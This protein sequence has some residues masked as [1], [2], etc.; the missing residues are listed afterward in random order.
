MVLKDISIVN[1]K[2]I[3]DAT[4]K[5]S[6]NINCFIGHNGEGKTNMLDAIYYMS[7]CRSAFTHTDSLTINHD[8]DFFVIQGNYENENGDCEE[9][10]CGMKRGSKKHIRRNK[11]EYRRFSEHIGLIPIIFISPSDT[12]L[13]DGGSEDRRHLLDIV[14]AQYDINYITALS[15]YNKALQQRNALL[16]A[17][18]EPDATLMELLEMQMAE[19]GET[20]YRKRDAF[21]EKLK[22]I[23]QDFYSRISQD[24][25]RVTLNYVSHCQ[26]GALLDVISRDRMKDRAV[27]YSLH[28]IHRDD[29]EMMIGDYQMKREASQGQRKTFVLALKLAQF[30]FLRQT[31]SNTTPLL[32]L[33]DIFDKLDASRVEQIVQL[34]SGDR[35]GQIFITDT[36]RE[37]LDSI[38][39]ASQDDYK[40]FNVE[41]GTFKEV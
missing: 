26:R 20:V 32:L 3:L 7:F 6:P 21:V 40:L 11:K 39:H 22:P 38:L 35:F 10:Y 34:V 15:Q 12:A 8:A 9:I 31:V 23:F 5:L 30:D 17:E 19:S 36:N 33:D 1:Y 13:I 24:K 4:L 2:N 28:G 14:I 27:G 16:R 29:L 41:N 37:H 18:E 25:E